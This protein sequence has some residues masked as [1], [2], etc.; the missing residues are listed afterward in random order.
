[1]RFLKSN[2]L[3]VLIPIIFA[4]IFG[5]LSF[6]VMKDYVDCR[7]TDYIPL[8]SCADDGKLAMSDFFNFCALISF[9]LSIFL[10]VIVEWQE[11]Q[12]SKNEFDSI[13]IFQN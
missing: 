3:L 8:F 13:K 5:W 6:Y 9:G 4:V 7:A 11:K 2:L 12:N 1:M 10:P